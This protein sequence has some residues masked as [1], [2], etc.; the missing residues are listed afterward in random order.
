MN[1]ASARPSGH[2]ESV[3]SSPAGL[4]P[5]DNGSLL[6]P[7]S[8]G[9]QRAK[10]TA[11]Y[12]ADLVTRLSRRDQAI[13]HDLARVRV[14]TG[15]QLERLHFYDLAA[16]NRDRARRRVLNPMPSRTA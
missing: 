7:S 2:A 1:P 9:R 12:V 5:S 15:N 6:P 16:A 10:V 11:A 14:L 3:H 13:L 4:P 8:F